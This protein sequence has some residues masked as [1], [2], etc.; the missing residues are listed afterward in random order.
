MAESRRCAAQGRGVQGPRSVSTFISFL[1]LLVVLAIG[2]ASF[3]QYVLW[4]VVGVLLSAA[5]LVFLMIALASSRGTVQRR[6]L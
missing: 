6:L 4:P 1:E 3:Q 5:A 2:D